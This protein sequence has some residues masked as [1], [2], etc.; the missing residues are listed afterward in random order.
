MPRSGTTLVERILGAHPQAAGLGERDELQALGRWLRPSLE[1]GTPLERLLREPAVEE[2]A[3]AALAR[4][5]AAGGGAPVLVDKM[6]TNFWWLGLAA[7]L[8]PRARVV[9]LRRH[10]LDNV[11]ACHLQYLS[12]AHGYSGRLEDAALYHRDHLRLMAHWRLAAALPILELRYEELVERPEE[13]V[14]RLLAFLELPWDARCL[15]FHEGR[16]LART[17]SYDQ[18]R[19]PLHREAVGRWRRYRELLPPEVLA[20]LAP[21]LDAA[22]TGGYR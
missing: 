9:H 17:A 2:A 22:A 3:R 7:L 5:R 4:L 16:G 15:R 21:Y 6:P 13:Q 12:G 8:F 19:Q 20:H 11:L 14:R 18:V 10:P 1:A